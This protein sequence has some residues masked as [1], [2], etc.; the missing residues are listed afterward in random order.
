M[1]RPKLKVLV[2]AAH[3][4]SVATSRMRIGPDE[5]KRIRAAEAQGGQAAGL[6]VVLELLKRRAVLAD[7]T[8]SAPGLQ[9]LPS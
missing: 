8:A 6:R 9:P 7:L 1:L 2:N 5:V 3:K 4:N